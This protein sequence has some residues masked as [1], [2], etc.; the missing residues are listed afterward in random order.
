VDDLLREEL[1]RRAERDQQARG[2]V[3]AGVDV[4]AGALGDVDAENLAWLRQTVREK[5]WPTR[6]MV[7]PDGAHAAWLLVQH[8]DCDPA[9][10]RQ[11]LDL[12]VAAAAAG[13][14][15]PQDVAY[16]TDR[17]FLAEGRP[18]EYGTQVTARSGRWA[19]RL[20]R[21]PDLVD[22]RRASVGPEPLATYLTWFGE[23]EPSVLPC[24]SCDARIE[25]WMPDPGE[26]IHLRCPSCGWN[27]P[28]G[29]E[30]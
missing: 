25:F 5:G 30:V 14:A 12:L 11:C 9:F 18:Q 17:V 6:S 7:G 29:I 3:G 4:D 28:L 26:T 13:E 2:A 16:L 27:S 8:A 21:D 1:L 22:A 15:S 19:P 23:P 20:L 10:Q 24:P